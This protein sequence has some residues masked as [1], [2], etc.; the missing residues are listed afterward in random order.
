LNKNVKEI[1][2]EF[3]VTFYQGKMVGTIII[4]LKLNDQNYKLYASDVF[5]PFGDIIDFFNSFV[6]NKLPCSVTIDEEG[7]L[8]RM[9][10][11]PFENLKLFKFVLDDKLTPSII[12]MEGIVD[13]RAFVKEFL[14]KFEL[15]L[16]TGYNNYLWAKRNEDDMMIARS[17]GM[18]I[19]DIENYPFNYFDL[20]EID[21]TELKEYL[22]NE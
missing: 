2:Q 5:P 4:T 3:K 18:T 21:L 12:F 9:N 15:F 22:D 20:R 7:K 13:R 8:T 14:E 11:Y 10:A 1:P 17:R 6:K 16:K 19:D